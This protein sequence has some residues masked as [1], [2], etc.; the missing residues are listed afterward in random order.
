LSSNPSDK[1]KKLR[2]YHD[3]DVA[4]A[5]LDLL[6]DRIAELVAKDP[7]KAAIILTEW[8]KQAASRPTPKKKAG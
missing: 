6:R 2:P 5:E 1:F 7:Q 3:Q 8:L 4:K